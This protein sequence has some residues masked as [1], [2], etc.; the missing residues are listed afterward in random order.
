MSY[1]YPASGGPI[2]ILREI[3]LAI[4]SGSSWGLLGVSGA[5][6]TTLMA[7]LAGLELP[8]AGSVRLMGRDLGTLSDDERADLRL[9]SVGF[10]FQTFH[11][12]ASLTALENVLFPL[13]LRRL[14]DAAE[15]A[16]TALAAVG[17]ERRLHHRPAALSGGEQQRVAL[18]RAFA[19]S[20]RVLFADEPTGHLDSGNAERVADLLFALNAE[21]GSTLILATHDRRL[22]A[23]CRSC[24]VL[25]DGCLRVGEAVT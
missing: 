3:D 1:G 10:V 7:L 9:Q 5:G 23:R 6:K 15:R 25:E 20:P 13:R 2:E 24:A 12:L 14:P 17:L 18:A 4:E 19:G 8:Q 21:Q 22:V 16:R 11:L